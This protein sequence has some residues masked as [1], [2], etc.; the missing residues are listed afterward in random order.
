MTSTPSE[1]IQRDT[2][3]LVCR[4]PVME[5]AESLLGSHKSLPPPF[6]DHDAPQNRM[7]PHLGGPSST[8][9]EMAQ[10]ISMPAKEIEESY[11]AQDD[12]VVIQDD[13]IAKPFKGKETD[14]A[15]PARKKGPL[16]LLD[17]PLD[18]LKD[19]FKEVSTCKGNIQQ[20][21]C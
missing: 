18:I 15:E 1:R 9:G 7:S 6:K 17:L 21:M 19:I 2:D 20:A 5:S 11:V 14:S 3:S 12:G 4:E 8:H 10:G 16:E 13:K